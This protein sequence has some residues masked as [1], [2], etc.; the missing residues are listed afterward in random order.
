MQLPLGQVLGWARRRQQR[1][2][3]SMSPAKPRGGVS[4]SETSEQK[5]VGLLVKW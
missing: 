5:G 3:L 1:A 2:G 4:T